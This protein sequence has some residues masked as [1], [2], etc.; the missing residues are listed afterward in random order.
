MC[1]R[2]FIESSH[3]AGSGITCANLASSR[4]RIHAN[5]GARTPQ[6]R[7]KPHHTS[8]FHVNPSLL[9]PPPC[10]RTRTLACNPSQARDDPTTAR[11]V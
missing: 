6:N 10:V 11:H 8:H 5:L 3:F 7:R 1:V 9:C 2:V 4:A